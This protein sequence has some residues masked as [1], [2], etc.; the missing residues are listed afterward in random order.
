[1]Q[2]LDDYISCIRRG[3]SVVVGDKIGAC[4]DYY[5]IPRYRYGGACC[6]SDKGDGDK[7]GGSCQSNGGCVCVQRI[8][9]SRRSHYALRSLRSLRPYR[10]LGAGNGNIALVVVSVVVVVVA[11]IT[12]VTA[13]IIVIVV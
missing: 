10:S 9:C 8:S 11:S 12:A 5:G 2:K 6:G 3:C 1:M 13:V 4:R 7:P